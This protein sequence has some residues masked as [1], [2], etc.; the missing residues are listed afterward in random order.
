MEE[1]RKFLSFN[2]GKRIAVIT[3]LVAILV[4]VLACVLHRPRVSLD[5]TSLRHLDSLLAL[6]NAAVEAQ[7]HPLSE[8]VPEGAAPLPAVASGDK[9]HRAPYPHEKTAYEPPVIPLV[10]LNTADS[11]ALVALPQIGP[12]S[13]MRILEYRDQLGCYVDI[14]QLREVKGMDSSRFAI[15]T[16]Y[17]VMSAA[18]P[19]K[20]DVNRDDFKTLLHHPYLN[21]GQV[22]SIFKQREGRGMIKNWAQLEAL[23]QEAGE[24]NPLLERYV[25]Y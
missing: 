7:Q 24:V 4:L 20:V 13:A 6:R 8:P 18:E 12:Y 1:L 23:I 10:D 17:L 21:Y 15:A 2:K 9:R 3:I 5:E 19:R 25:E 14:A 11:A 22:R 16:P